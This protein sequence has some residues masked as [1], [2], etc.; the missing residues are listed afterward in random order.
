M[1]ICIQKKAV[2]KKGV[3]ALLI[4]GLVTGLA[5]ALIQTQAEVDGSTISTGSTNLQI[6]ADGVNYSNSI[7]G[8]SFTNMLPGGYAAPANGYPVYL[9]NTG[10][11]DLDLSLSIPGT[12]SNPSDTN[13]NK[14][15]FVL[16][17][18]GSQTGPSNFLIGG[19]IGGP[20]PLEGELAPGAT[21]EYELQATMRPDADQGVT[22]SGINLAFTGMARDANDPN[23]SQ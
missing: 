9:K 1:R 7:P 16:T 22:V 15:S 10:S 23:Q 21:R 14:F 17:E 8:F 12:P 19:L 2:W 6:S 4:V 20:A 18:V 13:L 11:T 3:I 5:Y